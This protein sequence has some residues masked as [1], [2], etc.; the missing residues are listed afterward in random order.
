MR[1]HVMIDDEL[2]AEAL[3]IIGSKTD[4]RYVIVWPQR[5]GIAI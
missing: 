2:M 3:E 5:T 1:T 4:G